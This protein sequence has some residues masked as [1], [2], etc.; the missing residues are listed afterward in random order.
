MSIGCITLVF[1]YIYILH[2]CYICIIIIYLCDYSSQCAIH[3]NF[4]NRLDLKYSHYLLLSQKPYFSV[5]ALHALMDPKVPVRLWLLAPCSFMETYIG[6]QYGEQR[7]QEP[8]QLSVP[9]YTVAATLHLLFTD[10]TFLWRNY[11]SLREAT[12]VKGDIARSLG[13]CTC[14]GTHQPDRC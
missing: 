5:K 14:Q 7:G 6:T 11:S 10:L 12:Y 4:T 1:Y 13:A 2:I 3:L 9:R 8:S